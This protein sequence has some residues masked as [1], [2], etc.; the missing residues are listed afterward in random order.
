MPRRRK[1]PSEYRFL[2][3]VLTTSPALAVL[4]AAS[5]I[6]DV[7]CNPGIPCPPLPDQLIYALM[8]V[9]AVGVCGSARRWYRDFVKGDYWVDL[10]DAGHF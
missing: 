1:R 5:R 4:W 3:P 7:V 6:L 2:I 10:S 8:T 9:F